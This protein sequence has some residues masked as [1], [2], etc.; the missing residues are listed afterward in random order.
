M[1]LKL[2]F[3]NLRKISVFRDQRLRVEINYGTSYD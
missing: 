2:I 3:Q 1:K